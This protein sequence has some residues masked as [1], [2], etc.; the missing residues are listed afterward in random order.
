MAWKERLLGV[1]GTL[2]SLRTIDRNQSSPERGLDEVVAL[3]DSDDPDNIL[4]VLKT[5]PS[6]DAAGAV[7]RPIGAGTKLCI[8]DEGNSTS[9]ALDTNEPFIGTGIDVSEYQ[10]VILQISSDVAGA[11]N[12]IRFESSVDNVN[13]DHWHRYTYNANGSTHYEETLSAKYFRMVYVNGDVAQGYFRMQV[14]L[15]KTAA[16]AHV[17]SLTHTLSDDHPAS[18]VRSILA[19]SLDDDSRDYANVEIHK[20]NGRT[21]L[22]I[23]QGHRISEMFGREPIEIQAET[24]TTDATLYTVPE[25]YVLWVVSIIFSAT[26]TATATAGR[27]VL[28]DGTQ[29]GTMKIPL[30]IAEAGGQTG[31]Q[32]SV[33]PMTLNEPISFTSAVYM[34][35]TAGTLSVDVKLVGY[36]EPIFY[37]ST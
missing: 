23:G 28:R 25:D 21:S 31:G 13:W 1:A 16:T 5:D 29:A 3:S 18:V 15:L 34:D 22:A 19:G 10:A 6:S 20:A 36:L 12:G 27:V 4:R 37:A 30:R 2:F 11:A 33:V 7:V 35:I 14:K 9:E 24:Q 8:V 26:N 32:V 17:H